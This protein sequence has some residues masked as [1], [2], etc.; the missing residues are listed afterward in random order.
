MKLHFLGANRQVTGSCYCIEVAGS[1]VMVD[2][3]MF[4]EREFAE[5]NWHDCP[6]PARSV[7]A[8]LLTH[9]HIDHSGRLPDLVRRGFR[10]KIYATRPTKAMAE[11]MLLDAAG[12]QEED[13][14]YKRKR[15]QREGRD[16]SLVKALFNR[17]DVRNTLPL[18]KAVRYNEPVRVRDGVSAVFH[19]AGHILG[20]SILEVICRERGEEKRLIFSGDIGQWG[21]P[22]IRDPSLLTKADVV[23]MESTYGDRDH[24]E[25]GDVEAQ[26]EDVLQRTLR[27]GGNV[28]IPTFAVERAQELMYHISALVHDDRIP[29]VPI[30]LDSPMAV[31]VTEVF[32]RYRD[33]FDEETW[34]RI[35]SNEPPLRFPGL[36]MARTS[37]ESRAINDHQGPAVIMSTSGMCTAGRIKHHLRRN[38]GDKNSTVL[39]VGY[40]GRGTLGRQILE[41]NSEVR[42]HGKQHPVRAEVAQIY[43]FSGH[44]D[45]SDLMKWISHFE[46]QPRRLFL[47]HGEESSSLALAGRIKDELGWD[48]VVPEYQQMFNV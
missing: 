8:L 44:A 45:R 12:I 38:I 20:S 7:D 5:R 18:F 29:D 37:H 32:R 21:K 14:A 46:S 33:C 25:A 48:A 22:L 13:A 19:D 24:K 42:I 26:L 23:V 17:G 40:Q 43:G 30:F 1:R 36:T 3:G 10:G 16:P 28:V 35:N 34:E 2:C 9:I 39:F 11:I 47:T 6:V 27:R 15:H 31:D 41:G 4:Q